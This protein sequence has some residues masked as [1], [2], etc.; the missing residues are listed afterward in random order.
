MEASAENLHF[1][2][3]TRGLKGAVFGAVAAWGV[4]A[5]LTLGYCEYRWLTRSN[6]VTTF[7]RLVRDQREPMEGPVLG[8]TAVATAAGWATFAPRGRYRFVRSFASVFAGSL[9]MW[10]VIGA[11]GIIPRMYRGVSPAVDFAN[12]LSIG[13]SPLIVGLS[14]SIIRTC[15]CGDGN[16]FAEM[17]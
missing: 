13:L 16:S 14:L 15:R 3:I 9:A 12:D 6:D 17:N 5:L 10:A 8:C 7:L 11:S 2:N 4:L 1:L